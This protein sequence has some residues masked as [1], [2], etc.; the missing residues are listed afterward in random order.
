MGETAMTVYMFDR[1]RT[2]DVNGP[3]GDKEG[4]PLAWVKW[5]AHET[6]NPVF[7]TGNQHLR[8]EAA[9]PGLQE[10]KEIYEARTG[11]SAND[12]YEDDSFIEGY[13]PCRRDGLRLVKEIHPDEQDFVVI[14][15]IDLTDMSDEGITHYFPWDF[16]ADVRNEI[17]PIPEDAG[18]QDNK[19]ENAKDVDVRERLQ[20]KGFF[21]EYGLH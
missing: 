13:K 3:R 20:E 4:V 14:D 5:L 1:D 2:V 7:A 9:I 18:D 15:D 6:D 10:A 16:V 17:F 11:R 12:V 8:R 21:A 19:P